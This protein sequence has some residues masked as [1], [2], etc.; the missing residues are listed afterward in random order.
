MKKDF[1]HTIDT[2]KNKIAKF[3]IF[4]LRKKIVINFQRIVIKIFM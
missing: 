4:I 3:L 1:S 2:L